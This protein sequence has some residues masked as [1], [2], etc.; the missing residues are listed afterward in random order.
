MAWLT[1]GF[2]QKQNGPNAEEDS[3]S[4]LPG[5]GNLPK[6]LESPYL[7]KKRN[8]KEASEGHEKPKTGGIGVLQSASS[9]LHGLQGNLRK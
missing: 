9:P 6:N 2:K 8:Q 1:S 3:F 4:D 5:N 7:Y